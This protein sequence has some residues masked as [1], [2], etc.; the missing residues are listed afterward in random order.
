MYASGKAFGGSY[1]DI[2][3]HLGQGSD[4]SAAEEGVCLGKGDV[5]ASTQRSVSP[6]RTTR[7]RGVVSAQEGCGVQDAV[8]CQGLQHEA[9]T[10][11]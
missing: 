8:A 9:V 7:S 6:D 10:A 4:N 11:W 5:Q 3:C 1:P 2:M